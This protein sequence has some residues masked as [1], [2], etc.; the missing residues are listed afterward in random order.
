MFR[1]DGYGCRTLI[2]KERCWFSYFCE[3]A[4]INLYS[5]TDLIHTYSHFSVWS[6]VSQI[7]QKLGKHQ[8]AQPPELLNSQESILPGFRSC[9]WGWTTAFGPIRVLWGTTGSYAPAQ[10][11]C[12]NSVTSV[13]EEQWTALKAFIMEKMFLLFSRTLAS[14]RR[15]MVDWSDRLKLVCDGQW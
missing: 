10:F 1:W 3:S 12:D 5:Y 8:W 7:K 15:H 6:I 9:T 13:T 14:E 2:Y 11:R 4:Y